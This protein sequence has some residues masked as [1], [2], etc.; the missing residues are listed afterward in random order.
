MSIIAGAVVLYLGWATLLFVM[1][2]RMMFPGEALSQ[3]T[4]IGDGIPNGAEQLWIPFSQGRVEAWFM[5]E[6]S[7]GPSPAVIFAHGN[8][9]LIEHALPEARS[10]GD[11][12]LSVMLVEY[13]GYGRSDGRPSRRSVSEV[14]LAAYDWLATRS[15]VDR[16]R[17]VGMGRSLGGGAIT[18][19]ARER[20]LHA[21]VLQS[22]FTSAAHFAKRYFVPGVLVRDR[23]D[24][25]EVLRS[26][27]GPVLLVH[28]KRDEMISHSNSE[29]LAHAGASAE[30]LSLECGHNDCPP[31]WEAY[32][33]EL[34]GFLI[35]S[36]VL[37]AGPETAGPAGTT[38]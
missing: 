9:E 8:A 17:L 30:L 22:T 2:R 35:R 5:S 38:K 7:A 33:A 32:L 12:G 3:S 20:P 24:N 27:T 37:S 1:Q 36:E 16:E 11:L 26:F 13:P 21:L 10:L 31:D 29:R 4:T 23:F 6:R 34:R 15:D 19:L 28:G 14:F 18:D 25:L